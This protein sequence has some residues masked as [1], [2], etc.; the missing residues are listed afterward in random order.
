VTEIVLAAVVARAA[1]AVGGRRDTA[2][3][4]FVIARHA[5]VDHAD[6]DAGA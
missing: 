5:R 3:E 1:H 2:D 4:V 6:G